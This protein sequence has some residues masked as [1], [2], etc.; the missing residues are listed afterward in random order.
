MEPRDA[1]LAHIGEGDFVPH[2]VEAQLRHQPARTPV[3]MR[4]TPVGARAPFGH[5]PPLTTA[6]IAWRKCLLRICRTFL[7]RTL[8]I[9]NIPSP[10]Y[11]SPPPVQLSHPPSTTSNGWLVGFDQR[12]LPT[13]AERP[14][15]VLR[16]TKRTSRK[17]TEVAARTVSVSPATAP[18]SVTAAYL[19]RRV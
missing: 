7:L 9:S 3:S 17:Q 12:R 18:K 15:Q 19:R 6:N 2:R 8:P 14:Q 5:G 11:A 13:Q 10:V 16:L 4:T 1:I